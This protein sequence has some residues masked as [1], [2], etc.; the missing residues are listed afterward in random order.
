M[1]ISVQ[2]VKQRGLLSGLINSIARTNRRHLSLNN[3]L[4]LSR[5]IARLNF[6]YFNNPYTIGLVGRQNCYM[7]SYGEQFIE[8][9]RTEWRQFKKLLRSLRKK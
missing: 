7:V 5:N 1:D 8:G 9:E 3:M 6:S 2:F 4:A